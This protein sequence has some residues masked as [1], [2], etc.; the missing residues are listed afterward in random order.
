MDYVF[1]GGVFVGLLMA[2]GPEPLP[3]R[4]GASSFPS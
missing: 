1:A 3:I 2:I 4:S